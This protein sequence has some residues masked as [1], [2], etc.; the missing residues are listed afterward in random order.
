M[1]HHRIIEMGHVLGLV[2]TG[3]LACSSG[4]DP[5]KTSQQS[6]YKCQ[7]ATAEYESLAPG[8]TLFLENNGGQGK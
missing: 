7:L 6:S 5:N 3:N 2:G 1:C 4:C 8:K